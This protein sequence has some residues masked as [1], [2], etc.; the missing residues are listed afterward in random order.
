[1]ILAGELASEEAVKRFH[2]E[3]EA[4]ANLE[5]PNIVPIHEVGKHEDQHYFSM[6]FIDG[7]SLADKIKHGP[8]KPHAAAV[9]LM[10]I[11]EAIAFAHNEGVIH[12]DLK[13]G[14][15]LIDRNDE[16]ILGHF[17]IEIRG[18]MRG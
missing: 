8:L 10:K 18:R 3:A 15:V 9:Y 4:A 11:A 1:M 5:H 7:E 17:A 14:N 6:G 13:P 2:A 16:L 12:R